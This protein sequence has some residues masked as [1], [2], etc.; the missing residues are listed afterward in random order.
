MATRRAVV[1]EAA[2]RAVVVGP[3]RATIALRTLRT[4][5]EIPAWPIA[6]LAPGTVAPSMAAKAFGAATRV[7]LSAL[8]GRAALALE[9]GRAGSVA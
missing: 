2:R 6:L 8:T 5:P 9:A 3:A 1:I 7:V 4:V